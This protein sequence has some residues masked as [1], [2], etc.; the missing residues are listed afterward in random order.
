M[1][2]KPSPLQYDHD[3]SVKQLNVAMTPDMVGQRAHVMSALQL[4]PGERVLEVGCGNGLL[5]VQMVDAV[6]QQGHVIGVDVSHAMIAMARDAFTD[7]PNMQFTV[8]DAACLP[9]KDAS[10]DVA[11]TVQCLCFVP[12]VSAALSELLRVLRPGGRLVILDTDWDTL[13]WNSSRP[14]L[15]VTVMDMY[16]AVY[17]DARLPRILS[18]ELASSGFKVCARNQ[19]AILNWHLDPDTYSS[20]QIGFT[21]SVAES[22]VS[23]AQLDAWAQ[24]IQSAA[25]AGA[26]F[27][28]LNRYIFCASKP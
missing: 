28:N 1:H 7:H 19:F 13:V 11:V 9:I 15:M 25:D 14:E 24:G 12:D 23:R 4:R 22:S 6:G 5:A 26:Y 21:R 20:H 2:A 3:M 10:I 27:F 17:V 18:R 8:G 16:K